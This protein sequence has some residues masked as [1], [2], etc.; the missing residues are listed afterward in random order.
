LKTAGQAKAGRLGLRANA[1][2][3]RL[4]LG[5]VAGFTHADARHARMADSPC[6]VS[7]CFASRA[8]A[9]K[10][11]A[12]GGAGGRTVCAGLTRSLQRLACAALLAL[13]SAPAAAAE[14]V[15]VRL[16]IEADPVKAN[17]S[18]WDG[19]PAVGGKIV[20]PDSS[21]APDIAVCVVQATGAPDC[22]WRTERKRKVSHCPDS[23]T[24][25]IPGIRLPAFPVGL[26][27]LDTDL[28][29]HDLI[30]FVIL[31]DKADASPDIARVEANLRAVMA[32]LTP[33]LTARERE[34]RRRKAR[35]L[36]MDLCVGANAKCDLSQ[37][38]FWLERQ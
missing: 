9:A 8:M 29:R 20:A 1:D 34:H 27:F 7:D 35:V 28:V 11:A 16:S 33:G 24:C 26:I 19:Y 14:D 36:P 18:P 22:V 4:F 31:T 2:T 6:A 13:L 32:N 5:G 21:N 38:R 15:V 10:I 25:T 30:D 3:G 37:S 17:G 23:T 12:V